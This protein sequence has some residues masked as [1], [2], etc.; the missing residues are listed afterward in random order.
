[1]AKNKN[2]KRKFIVYGCGGVTYSAEVE[3]TSFE[4]ALKIAESGTVEWDT[5]LDNGHEPP[6]L[7][8]VLDCETDEAKE[9]EEIDE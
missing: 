7:I 4:E 1:M 8:S 5:E 6:E 9:I 3:A 2:K